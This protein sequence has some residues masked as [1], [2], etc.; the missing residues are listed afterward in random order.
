MKTK[1]KEDF[2]LLTAKQYKYDVMIRACSM[3]GKM[4]IGLHTKL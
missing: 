1:R 2:H 3:H 4:K